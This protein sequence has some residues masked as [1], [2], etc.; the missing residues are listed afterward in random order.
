MS[1]LITIVGI[2]GLVTLLSSNLQASWYD[3]ARKPKNIVQSMSH[4][5]TTSAGDMD[6]TSTT[7]TNDMDLTTTTSVSDMDYTY[8]TSAKAKKIN[9]PKFW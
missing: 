2:I 6:Y 9:Y 3:I 4:T 8:T 7:S 1:K 5:T